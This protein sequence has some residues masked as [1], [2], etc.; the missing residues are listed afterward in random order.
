MEHTNNE[1]VVEDRRY[2]NRLVSLHRLYEGPHSFLAT[3]NQWKHA[4]AII[5]AGFAF[6]GYRSVMIHLLQLEWGAACPLLDR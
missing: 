4:I 2:T 1:A 6:F 5:Y 3:Q